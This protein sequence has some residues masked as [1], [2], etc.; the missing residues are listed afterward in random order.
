[1]R[2]TLSYLI[3]SYLY[4]LSFLF[5]LNFLPYSTIV[6]V[7]VEL[8]S[9]TRKLGEYFLLGSNENGSLHRNRFVLERSLYSRACIYTSPFFLH[10]L[11]HPSKKRNSKQSVRRRGKGKKFNVVL[12]NLLSTG[13]R[14]PPLSFLFFLSSSLS[15]IN[16]RST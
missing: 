7:D 6:R 16:P 5:S 12:K 2:K 14:F 15:C 11:F 10:L 3:L 13:Y 9:V 1:M 4:L 8:G